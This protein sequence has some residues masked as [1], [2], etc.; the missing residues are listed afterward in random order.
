[1]EDRLIA[2]AIPFFIGS[3]IVEWVVCR[4]KGLGHYYRLNDSLANLANGLGQEAIGIIN[5]VVYIGIYHWVFTNHSFFASWNTQSVWQWIVA[6]MIGDICYYWFHRASHRVN[7]LVGSHVVHHQSE[8]YNLSVAL[9][10]SWLTRLYGW[11]F[12]LP[13]ALIGIPT[14]MFIVIGAFNLIYQ[15]WVHTRLINRL[16]FLEYILV[17]P[18]H[19][20]VHHGRNP[21]YVDK[22]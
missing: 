2:M 6:F 14:T 11:A 20:R 5:K 15:F 18:S 13:M 22:N 21:E 3:M 10:Q 8:E 17:T 19:H 4:K 12:Y 7:L 16:G 1:M 9:R